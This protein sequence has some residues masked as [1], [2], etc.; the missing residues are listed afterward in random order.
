VERGPRLAS[1]EDPDVSATIKDILEAEGIAIVLNADDIRVA[2]D[3]DR[4]AVT[5]RADAA[6]MVG[7]TCWW[8]WAA[9]P[10]PTTSTAPAC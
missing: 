8:R 7:S 3:G 5:P 2:R 9:G 4:V 10:T 6:T 1:R